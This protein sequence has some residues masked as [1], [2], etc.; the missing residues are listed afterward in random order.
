MEFTVEELRMIYLSLELMGDYKEER[1][2]KEDAETYR[3][4][5]EKVHAE[6]RAKQKGE[7]HV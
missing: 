7:S 4:L 1:R 3:N 5:A 2:H 6:F